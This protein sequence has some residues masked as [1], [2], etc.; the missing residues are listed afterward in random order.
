MVCIHLSFSYFTFWI[1][2]LFAVG[3][4]KLFEKEDFKNILSF[5]VKY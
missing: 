4:I 1:S 2:V 3:R 5:E